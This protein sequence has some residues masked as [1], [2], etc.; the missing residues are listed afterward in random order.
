MRREDNN[1]YILN[2]L[3]SDIYKSITAFATDADTTVDNTNDITSGSLEAMHNDYHGTIGGIG[4]HMASVPIAA[5]D[6]IFFL[7][8]V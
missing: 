3:L 1:R 2:I 6:P 8:H 4:G 5:F 7:H